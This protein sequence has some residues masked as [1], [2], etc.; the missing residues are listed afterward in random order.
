MVVMISL[1]G[2]PDQALKICPDGDS[3][4]GSGEDVIGDIGRRGGVRRGEVIAAGATGGTA[5]GEVVRDGVF[6]VS[7]SFV[8]G[9]GGVKGGVGSAASTGL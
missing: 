4:R 1:L 3:G 9:N 7:A 8:M 5:T 6:A 2:K